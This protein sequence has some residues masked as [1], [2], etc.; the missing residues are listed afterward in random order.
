MARLCR[1]RVVTPLLILCAEVVAVLL[2][3][4]C[5]TQDHPKVDKTAAGTVFVC[6]VDV[7]AGLRERMKQYWNAL[8]QEQYDVVYDIDIWIRKV[9]VAA[10][11]GSGK[12]AFVRELKKE[13]ADSHADTVGANVLRCE[14]H[15][16]REAQVTVEASFIVHGKELKKIR[17][18]LW[19]KNW[20]GKWYLMEYDPG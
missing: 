9:V 5:C 18:E 2:T 19:Q 1:V 12:S 11:D 15:S 14:R 4:A 17:T 13:S 7:P 10:G 16:D 8:A 3:G 6:N 20:L